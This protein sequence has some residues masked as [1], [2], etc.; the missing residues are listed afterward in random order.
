MLL[1]IRTLSLPT[2][3]IFLLEEV[4]CD[5]VYLWRKQK[6]QSSVGKGQPPIIKSFVLQCSKDL[7]HSQAPQI[8]LYLTEGILQEPKEKESVDRQS[9]HL[10]D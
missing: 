7:I 8:T 1:G 9:V 3:K 6:A 2:E 10:V 5:L 4:M